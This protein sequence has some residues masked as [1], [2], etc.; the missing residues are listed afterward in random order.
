MEMTEEEL[1]RLRDPS[2]QMNAPSEG[3]SIE[4]SFDNELSDH[5]AAERLYYRSTLF[6]KLDKVVG[7]ALIVVGGYLIHLVG[8]IWWSII[9]I[10]IG[11]FEISNLLSL[12]PI[13]VRLWFKHN[14]KF[15]ETY[16]LKVSDSGIHFRTTSIDSHLRWD[17]YSRFLENDL[18]CLLIY[19]S[20]MYTVIPKRSFHHPADLDAFREIVNRKLGPGCK[21]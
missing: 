19:G 13:Q 12:R 18:I 4:I 21:A 20:R 3:S 5:L 10:P 2:D 15:R 11:L 16:H 14:P 6:W 1:V 9:W 17:H 7:T 8:F